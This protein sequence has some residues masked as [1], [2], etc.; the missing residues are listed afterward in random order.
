MLKKQ[1]HRRHVLSGLL[2]IS[3]TGSASMVASAHRQKKVQSTVEWN[4]RSSSLEIIHELHRHDAEQALA[5]LGKLKRP[6]LTSLKS[7]AVLALYVEEH[8]ALSDIENS[9]LTLDIVGAEIDSARIYV[10]LEVN[11]SARPKGLMIEN[12]I[13][14]DVYADQINHV[15]VKLGGNIRSAVFQQGDKAKKVLA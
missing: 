8:F 11:M 12:K 10:Y 9:Q 15:N 4:E 13:F 5:L 7:R 14:H 2:A 1:P 3:V 6:D